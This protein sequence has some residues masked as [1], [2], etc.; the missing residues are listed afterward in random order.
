MLGTRRTFLGSLA[1]AGA[2][3]GQRRGATA[4]SNSRTSPLDG[5]T[6]EKIR[7]T[8]VKLI[9]LAYRL[10]PEEQWP[11]ADN[12]VIIWK[13]E[14]VIVQLSTDA[15]ITGI[16]GC[17]RYNGPEA[18]KQYLDGVIK[19]I[20]VGK[21]PFDVESLSGGVSGSGARGAWSGVDT[22]LWDIIGKAKGVPLYKLLAIDTEPQTHVHVYASGGEYTWLKNSRFPGPDHL[23]TEAL[24][25][26]KAGYTAFKFR[27]GG[28]FG[29]LGITIKE[30]I[31]YIRK[32]REAVGPDFDLIQESN[33][34]WSLEQCL[35]IAPVLEELKFLWWEE[36]T[37]RTIDNY[38]KIKQALKTVKVSGGEGRANRGEL[39]EWVDRGAYDIIQPGCDD[40]GV[41]EAWHMARMAHTR[42]KLLCPHNWQ[43]GLVAIANAHLM[44][45]VPNR[46]LLETNMTPNPL[47]EGLFKEKL[48][49]KNGY[50]DIPNKPGLGVEL[51][52]GLEEQ[53][54]PLPGPWNIPDPEMPK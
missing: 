47:K 46:F 38:L 45:A 20:L 19:P 35:E 6:R 29:K 22:A 31:P 48:A 41:T 25:Y 12:N 44:A 39:A 7:I 4:L 49:V 17:S 24:D 43:D 21:S 2:L 15:G 16:G 37:R 30:Y 53:Y 9:N 32:L 51:K 36:P 11:D 50:L 42:G 54:P 10:K 13:T 26:K 1:G 33:T 23:I 8:D 5:V 3:V 14:S 18:M 27:P 52:E 28:G 34:R 40:A